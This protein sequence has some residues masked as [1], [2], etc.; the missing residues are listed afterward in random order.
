MTLK[1][2]RDAWNVVQNKSYGPHFIHLQYYTFSYIKYV[3]K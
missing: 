3:K 1:S 2:V